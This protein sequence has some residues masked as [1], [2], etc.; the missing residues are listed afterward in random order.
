MYKEV[1]R[2]EGSYYIVQIRDRANVVKMSQKSQEKM[3]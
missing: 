3:F 2:P 1:G